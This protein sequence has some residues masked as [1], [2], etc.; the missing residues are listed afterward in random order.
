MLGADPDLQV[1]GQRG[2]RRLGR[3]LL[4]AIGVDVEAL[5]GLAADQ[6]ARQAHGRDGR[7]A[8]ARLVEKLSVDGLH[9][10]V[11]HVQRRQVQQFERA[12]TET[13]L[14]AHDGVH[15]GEGGYGFLRHAQALGIHAAARVVHDEARHVL[16]AHGRVAH[17]AGQIGQRVTHLGRAAQ[18]VDDFH[19]LHQRDRV[20]E[21]VA[22]HALRTLAGGRDG[23]DGQRRRIRRQ[24]AVLGHYAF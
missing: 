9:D 22:G 2:H 10:G 24:D 15:L 23:G 4:L 17:A 19:H 13:R 8:E 18:A 1:G 3:H 5:A 20:E 21:V 7:R 14:L 12:H 16:G 11:G 6:A